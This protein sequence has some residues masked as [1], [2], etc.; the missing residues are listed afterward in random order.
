MINVTFFK[1]GYYVTLGY[2][3]NDYLFLYG[4]LS[5]LNI[6]DFGVGID[7]IIVPNDTVYFGYDIDTDVDLPTVGFSYALSDRLS[8]KGQVLLADISEKLSRPNSSM[9]PFRFSR[10]LDRY[11]LAVSVFF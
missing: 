8:F 5:K 1:N 11:A 7:S 2:Y 6:R 10:A 4:S 3:V 9:P